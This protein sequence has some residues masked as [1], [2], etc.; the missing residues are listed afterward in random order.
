MGTIFVFQLSM[1]LTIVVIGFLTPMI[2]AILHKRY[3]SHIQ[4]QGYGTILGSLFVL[5]KFK[6]VC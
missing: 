6:I 3:Y 5:I 2:L 4:L 1:I